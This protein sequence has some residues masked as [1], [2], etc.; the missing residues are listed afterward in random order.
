[1]SDSSESLA[2]HIGEQIKSARLKMGMTQADLAF[3]AGM[4]TQSFNRIERGKQSMN[5]ER[6]VA[7]IS[8]LHLSSD[9]VLGMD[10]PSV[11]ASYQDELAQLLS[12]CTPRESQAI[13]KLASETKAVFHENKEDE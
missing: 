5:L 3:K 2:K 9:A 10:V 12:D 1:M 8:V 6:F 13:I 7:I 4:S 11:R